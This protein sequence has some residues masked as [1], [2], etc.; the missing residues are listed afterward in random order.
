MPLPPKNVLVQKM[1][2]HSYEAFT[3]IGFCERFI[4]VDQIDFTSP[5]KF[6]IFYP[7]K[8]LKRFKKVVLGTLWKISTKLTGCFGA[9]LPHKSSI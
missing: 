9:R 6:V 2:F 4:Q 5:P 8:F 1:F 7:A 3:G